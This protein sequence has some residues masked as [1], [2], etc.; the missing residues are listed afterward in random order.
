[1]GMEI[2]AWPWGLYEAR[3]RASVLIELPVTVGCIS[4]VD[5]CLLAPP[6]LSQPNG[7]RYHCTGGQCKEGNRSCAQALAMCPEDRFRQRLLGVRPARSIQ[8]RYRASIAINLNTL[9]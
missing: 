1:M 8:K 4:S 7:G 2:E 9:A 5:P 6:P 3:G